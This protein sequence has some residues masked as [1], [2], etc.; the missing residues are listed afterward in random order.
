MIEL[1]TVAD[2][3]REGD[4]ISPVKRYYIANYLS[5]GNM[6][7]TLEEAVEKTESLMKRN[8][9]DVEPRFILEI[10][11]VCKNKP[12]AET[13]IETFNMDEYS[14]Q[15]ENKQDGI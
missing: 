15:L 6:F 13:Y 9:F 4:E 3:H 1:P 8:P 12:A 14:K 7:D 5:V 2:Y 10:K 11:R